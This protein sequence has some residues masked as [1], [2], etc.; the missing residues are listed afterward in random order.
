MV[1]D[2]QKRDTFVTYLSEDQKVQ[3]SR[4]GNNMDHLRRNT[5]PK[6]LSAL[7]MVGCYLNN[8]NDIKD[9]DEDGK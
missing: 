2:P 6:T 3:V 1:F 9:E 4:T 7:A 5:K 8:H